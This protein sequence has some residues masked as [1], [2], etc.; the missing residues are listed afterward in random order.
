VLD[1]SKGTLSVPRLQFRYTV[2]CADECFVENTR[3]VLRISLWVGQSADSY[4]IL[5]VES[6]N[7]NRELWKQ[8]PLVRYLQNANY[9]EKFLPKKHDWRRVLTKTSSGLFQSRISGS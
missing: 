4:V 9:R 3:K 1:A 2:D 8:L 6:L 5:N 7:L